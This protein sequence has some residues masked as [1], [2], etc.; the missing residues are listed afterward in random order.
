MK[1]K[2]NLLLIITTF[3]MLMSVES[4]AG[5]QGISFYYGLGLGA[6]AP[7]DFDVSATGDLMFGIEEDGWALE[8]IGYGSV[9]AGSNNSA[10]DYSVSGNHIGLA[11]RTIEKDGQWY[12]FKVS[13]TD[14][15]F[16]LSN[17]TTDTVTSG[18]SYTFGWGM[19]M[20]REARLEID[21]SYYKSD[22]LADAVH[23]ATVR[24]FWGGSEYQGSSY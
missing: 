15:D 23:M 12:K 6:V 11:Y 4:Q 5:R 8:L 3:F 7:T 20:N 24:Y 17:T 19:R 10:V 9:E 1:F 2:Q 18:N 16:D 22:D 21:Y 14:M 13:G